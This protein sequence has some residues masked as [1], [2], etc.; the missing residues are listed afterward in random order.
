MLLEKASA[1][2]GP[3]PE[4]PD[5]EP[6]EEVRLA[7]VVCY[8]LAPARSGFYLSRSR[9][10]W[11]ARA[12]GTRIPFGSRFEVARNLLAA[13]GE[14]GRVKEVLTSLRGEVTVWERAYRRWSAEHLG[15]APLACRWLLR[16]ARTREM[17]GRLDTLLD[18][19]LVL[20][21][22]DEERG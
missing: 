11:I 22:T 19:P 12:A 9:L 17:L 3:P 10:G 7:D 16:I 18:S 4:V 6:G 14:S 20:E 8:L 1:C 13:A 2:T 21:Y 5:E 15:W